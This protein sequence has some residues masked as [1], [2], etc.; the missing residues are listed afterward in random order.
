MFGLH[1]LTPHETVI[2]EPGPPVLDQWYR[3]ELAPLLNMDE[4]EGIFS[5]ILMENGS[6]KF[7]LLNILIRLHTVVNQLLVCAFQ[8][9]RACF[10]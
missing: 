5:L 8:K 7:S 10:C 9:L 6:A 4:V 1:P 3:T 2:L